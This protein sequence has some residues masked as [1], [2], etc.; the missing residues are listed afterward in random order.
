M[1]GDTAR[2]FVHRG[3]L[4]ISIHS[5]R[6]GGD[7]SP[8]PFLFT[9]FYFN[10]LR[11]CGRRLG[12]IDR[13]CSFAEFQS[14]PPVWAETGKRSDFRFG[15]HISIHSARVGGD[16]NARKWRNYLIISIHSARV[17]GDSHSHSYVPILLYF[18]PLRPCGRRPFSDAYSTTSLTFQSTPPVWAETV[19]FD[20]P[21]FADVISIHSARVGG[22]VWSFDRA[23][24]F[25]AFQSTPPVWAETRSDQTRK[26]AHAISIHSARVGGD[27][28]NIMII[29]DVKYFNPLRPCGRRR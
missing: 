14:T 26:D 27:F 11:P 8:A 4:S 7:C 28:D 6:V 15:D 29:F 9:D 19:T 17:G 25:F 18:N 12:D 23:L 22:D 2:Y 10:P 5:A 3:D 16:Q 20:K 24:N 13:C 1:G 21:N